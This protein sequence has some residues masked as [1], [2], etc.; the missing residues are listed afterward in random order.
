MRTFFEEVG[1]RTS[2]NAVQR[3]YYIS[4]LPADAKHIV[5]AVRAHGGIEN[6]VHW[7]LDVSFGEDASR[8]RKG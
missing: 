8:I 5:G 1:E 7:V 3:R 6:Q 4:S 2:I